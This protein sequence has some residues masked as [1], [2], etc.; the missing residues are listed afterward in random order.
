METESRLLNKDY[1]ATRIRE[2]KEVR[3]HDVKFSIDE[4]DRVFSKSLYINFYCLGANEVWVKYSTVRIS[5]H[6][7]NSVPFPQ[8]I[9]EPD[10]ELKKNK[11]KQ[12]MATLTNAV[13]R[14]KFKSFVTTFDKISGGQEN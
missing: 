1:L 9:I 10:K 14:A 7:I 4:S 2:I 6:F 5:D 3:R 8:F 12:L 13:S 11:K